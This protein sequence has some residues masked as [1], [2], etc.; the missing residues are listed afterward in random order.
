MSQKKFDN[1]LVAIRE[2]ICILELSKMLMY[3]F[4]YD[5]IRNIYDNKSSLIHRH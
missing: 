4:H 5:S 1:N 2:S 3:E